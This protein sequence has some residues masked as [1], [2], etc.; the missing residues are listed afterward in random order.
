VSASFRFGIEAA[1]ALI[2]DKAMEDSRSQ[3]SES[4]SLPSIHKGMGNGLLAQI[5]RNFLGESLA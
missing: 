1:R 4:S 3:H 2:R 5:K